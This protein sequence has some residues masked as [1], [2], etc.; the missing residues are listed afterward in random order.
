M[1]Y[2]VIQIEMFF[3][4]FASIQQTNEKE[5]KILKISN[6]MGKKCLLGNLYNHTRTK[7]KPYK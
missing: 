1:A 6:Y 4:E 5:R 2:S 3:T 7:T